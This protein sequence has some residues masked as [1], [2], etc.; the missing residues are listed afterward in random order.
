VSSFNYFH[1][2]LSLLQLE[3]TRTALVQGLITS[4]TA[5]T[6]GLIQSSRF[7]LIDFIECQTE[8]KYQWVNKL[9]GDL[10]TILEANL[11]DDRYA[12]PAMEMSAFLVDTYISESVVNSNNARFVI[13]LLLLLES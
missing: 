2:L 8:N 4:A 10:V 3:S 6:E 7:S 11:A 13:P 12:I 5:G 9:I 1:Q